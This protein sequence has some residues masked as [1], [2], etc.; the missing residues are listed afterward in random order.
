MMI[1]QDT[2]LSRNLP[3]RAKTNTLLDNII[4]RGKVDGNFEKDF[5]IYRI[6]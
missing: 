1:V 2:K 3:A 4:I 6:F 5:D